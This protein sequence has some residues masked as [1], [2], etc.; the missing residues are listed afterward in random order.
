HLSR[1]QAADLVR[2]VARGKPMPEDIVEQIVTKAQGVPLFVEEIARSVV[3]AGNFMRA[4]GRGLLDR[5]SAI[6]PTLQES[7]LARLDR[8]G[9]AKDVAFTASILGR[10]FSYELIKAV[11][12]VPEAA[13]LSGLEQLV[14]SEVIWQRGTPPQ[15]RYTFKHA[16]IQD[17]AYQSIL[18]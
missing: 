15:A 13:L 12:A 5:S 10:E 8:L 11:S 6:P 7:L 3:E 2:Y 18:K 17:A 4:D 1:R 16:L 9:P 14:R